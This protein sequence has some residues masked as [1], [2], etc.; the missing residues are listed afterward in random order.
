METGQ[1]EPH[2]RFSNRR[3]P[4]CWRRPRPA[5]RTF[6]PCCKVNTSSPARPGGRG[7][8]GNARALGTRSIRS[9]PPSTFP[10]SHP[11]HPGAASAT[12]CRTGQQPTAPLPSTISLESPWHLTSATDP[13]KAEAGSTGSSHQ[14]L[15]S[16]SSRSITH[17]NFP[18]TG[19]SKTTGGQ[20]HRS[21]HVGDPPLR[22][23]AGFGQAL[24]TMKGC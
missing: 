18:S 24:D 22:R 15:T 12:S 7:G 23:N 11:H 2:R 10:G 17:M 16:L 3:V 13:D 20:G 14:T 5:A 19:E 1:P 9:M 6:C 4:R 8:G 21:R